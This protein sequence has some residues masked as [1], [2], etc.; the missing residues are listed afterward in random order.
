MSAIDFGDDDRE[1]DIDDSAMYAIAPKVNTLR[2]EIS[3][4]LN[5]NH[6]GELVS[7]KLG[8]IA[9]VFVWTLM[10]LFYFRFGMVSA[11]LLLVDLTLVNPVF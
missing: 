3:S 1:N 10:C 9:F 2:K 5:D 11:L 8:S 6:R 7:I 4:Q